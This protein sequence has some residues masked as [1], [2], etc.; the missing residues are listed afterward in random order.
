MEHP[1][2]G[3]LDDLTEEQLLAKITELNQKLN[4]AARMG[5]GAMANQ[6]RM[7]IESYQNRYRQC[8]DQNR[9]KDGVN[10]DDKID[11]Q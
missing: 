3:P 5:N 9:K 6:L 10:F 1:L 11:I 2:I 4:F 8:L 7:A